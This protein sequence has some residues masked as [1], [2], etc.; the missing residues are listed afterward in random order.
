M[1]ENFKLDS[2]LNDFKVAPLS[3]KFLD[4]GLIGR[5]NLEPDVLWVQRWDSGRF[6][7]LPGGNGLFAGVLNVFYGNSELWLG[8]PASV[9]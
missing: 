3:S 4:R 1:L 5:C 8:D 2:L 9:G 7:L 6:E